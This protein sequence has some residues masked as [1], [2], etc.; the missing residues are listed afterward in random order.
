MKKLIFLSI[1]I[2]FL[3]TRLFAQPEFIA[4]LYPEQHGLNIPADAE[5]HI[6]FQN[7]L[8]E[9]S[10]TDSAIYIYSDITGLHKWHYRLQNDGTDLYL[11][12]E[13]W[14]GVG[15]VPFN[16]GERVTITLTTRLRYANGAPFEGFTWDYTVAVRQDYGGTFIP[17]ATFGGPYDWLCF[18]ANG[19][20]F[21]DVVLENSTTDRLGIFFNDKK[22]K[23][24]FDHESQ[25]TIPSL[26][27]SLDY[28]RNG[29]IDISVF[30]NWIQLNDG[31]GNFTEKRIFPSQTIQKKI[32]DFNNDGIFDLV[33]ATAK[34]HEWLP[35]IF[36]MSSKD[37]TA[38]SDTLNISTLPLTP[39]YYKA[40]DSYD[41]DNDGTIDFIMKGRKREFGQ[42]YLQGFITVL[43]KRRETPSLSQL[44]LLHNS[45]TQFY[46]NDFNGD[47]WMDYIFPGSY[48]DSP[49]H[50]L[51]YLND[52][53][54]HL[55][56]KDAK[57]D[58]GNFYWYGCGG[59]VD[60][61]GD[62]DLFLNRNTLI[63]AMPEKMES[64]FTV[65]LNEGNGE[66]H[67]SEPN[68]L[69]AEISG[70]GW[71]K[72]VDLDLDGDL[73]VLLQGPPAGQVV[74]ANGSFAASVKATY[75]KIPDADDVKL[76]NFPN[77]FN[78]STTIKLT[79]S[80]NTMTDGEI[81]I[82][83][84]RGKLVKTFILRRKYSNEYQIMWRGD[85][86]FNN[87]VPSGIYFLQ[88]KFGN[89]FKTIK[90]VLVR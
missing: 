44:Q 8:D 33:T 57:L 73:D 15:N 74:I 34:G 87:K 18:D 78:T 16:A 19:D 58:S 36:I 28:D 69:P 35:D 49:F 79:L 29:A 63:S 21:P 45:A 27:Q 88:A 20:R 37:G 76:M 90:L 68:P 5:L 4:S 75:F 48:A 80:S 39:A 66:F 7:L 38:F 12:P 54:G 64:D 67:F 9:S 62:I 82:F 31:N 40:G 32:Y 83:D 51:I 24:V 59:D 86:S 42:P 52:G 56:M 84:I 77:P 47:G 60:G 72:L 71:P 85:D 43:M 1:N 53:T 3:L 25:M 30:K 22:G 55:E 14:Y 11:Q 2:A 17:L 50:D 65:A 89:F 46:G 26:D 6:G 13:H 41:L 70:Y 23:L 61:D 10:I 81:R